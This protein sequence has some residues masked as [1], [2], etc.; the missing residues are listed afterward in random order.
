[1]NFVDLVKKLTIRRIVA[2]WLVINLIAGYR[3][4][5]FHLNHIANHPHENG[6]TY[7]DNAAFQTVAY[8]WVWGFPSL[9]ALVLCIAAH[10]WY[11]SR[12]E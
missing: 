3:Y 5:T 11:Q 7:I 2:S 4:V 12:V 6:E 9:M 1:M 8:L 10:M